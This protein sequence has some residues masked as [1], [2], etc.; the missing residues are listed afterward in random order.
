MNL[1]PQQFV[2]HGLVAFFGVSTRIGV[3]LRLEKALGIQM[4][5]R[6][7]YSELGIDG[8][9]NLKSLDK[10]PSG[11]SFFLSF[12]FPMRREECNLLGR[13]WRI[14]GLLTLVRYVYP[15]SFCP[16]VTILVRS[17]FSWH[18]NLSSISR[19]M[20]RLGVHATRKRNHIL[21]LYALF[22]KDNLA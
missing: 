10:K 15:V 8:K 21:G 3:F 17:C 22:P 20:N 14:S 19:N 2:S 18:Q 5:R 12:A 11:P 13:A 6:S 16:V 7:S 9:W 1:T 4:Q